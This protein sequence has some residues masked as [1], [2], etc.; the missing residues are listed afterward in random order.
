MHVL[1][2]IEMV[3]VWVLELR[4]AGHLVHWCFQKQIAA[5]HLCHAPGPCWSP[6]CYYW[7][8]WVPVVIEIVRELVPELPSAR[9]VVY[10]GYQKQIIPC[11]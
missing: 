10:G 9:N 3:R 11:R 8:A 7:I 1:V 5:L 2:V 4:S 6:S